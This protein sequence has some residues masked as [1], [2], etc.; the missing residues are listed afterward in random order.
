MLE[1]DDRAVL[2][3]DKYPSGCRHGGW[4]CRVL[5]LKPPLTHSRSRLNSRTCHGM[6]DFHALHVCCQPRGC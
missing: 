5:D 1:H 4:E 2:L 6:S 3:R